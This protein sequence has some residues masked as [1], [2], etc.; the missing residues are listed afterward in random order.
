VT[1]LAVKVVI[2]FGALAKIAKSDYS[3]RHVC[4]PIRLSG[5]PSVRMEQ[6]GSHVTDFHEIFYFCI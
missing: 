4:P 6:L 5:Y 2:L 3:L 1:G